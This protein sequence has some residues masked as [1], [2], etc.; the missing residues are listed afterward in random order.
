MGMPTLERNWIDAVCHELTRVTGWPTLFAPARAP[1][2]ASAGETIPSDTF[3]WKSDIRDRDRTVGT[4]GILVP[5]GRTRDESYLRACEYADLVG[6]LLQRVFVEQSTAADLQTAA[7]R[8]ASPTTSL[9]TSETD[10][11]T[12]AVH[13]ALD[14]TFRLT[15]LRAAALFAVDPESEGFR[16]RAV[17]THENQSPLSFTRPL[18][19]P[20]FDPHSL[21]T[22]PVVIRRKEGRLIEWLPEEMSLGICYGIVTHDE[23][24]G[25]LWVFDR[26]DRRL[27][28]REE[29]ALISIASRLSG[30]I[31]RAVLTE[32]SAL[33]RKLRSELRIASE[34]QTA[35]SLSRDCLGGW[36]QLTSR[37]ETYREVGGD[38]CEI[39][40]LDDN[41]LLLAVGD[42]AGHSVPAAMVMATVRGALRVAANE[43]HNAELLP[44]QIITRLNQV[45]HGVVES[46]QFMTLVCAVLDRRQQT[47][48]L[49]NAGHPPVLLIRDGEVHTLEQPG[50]L[51]GVV[52][53]ATYD[54]HLVTLEP[55]DLLVLYTDGVTE[56]RSEDQ[57]L[58]LQDGITNVVLRHTEQPAD[59]VVS[60]VWDALEDHL[61]ETD[62]DDRTLLVVRIAAECSSS[63]EQQEL[64]STAS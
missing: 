64:I 11:W 46:N 3:S 60:H 28:R 17:R 29:Q 12:R 14:V 16:L 54:S 23:L 13:R 6:Q 5:P 25:M 22:S 35:Q 20:P 45:L 34:S 30:L 57:Q 26:R 21:C 4:L 27:T 38:L 47:I 56:A 49:A 52:A 36:C 8:S 42:A 55:D 7:P 2:T 58:F 18:A 59:D 51:L 62:H 32:E 44:E 19:V 39:L 41:R 33:Q 50:L 40:S 1:D 48:R 43:P 9:E 10:P 61:S 31:D 24:R 15:D 53:D 63:P 37:T